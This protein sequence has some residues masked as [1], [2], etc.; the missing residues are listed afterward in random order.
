MYMN[1]QRNIAYNMDWYCP[2]VV[3]LTNAF[4]R[5]VTFVNLI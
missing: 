5:K 3:T 1:M 4:N 2:L